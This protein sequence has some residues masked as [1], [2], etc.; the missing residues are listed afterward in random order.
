MIEVSK[1]ELNAAESLIL[2]VSLRRLIELL[3]KPK[4]ILS[5][6]IRYI[7]IVAGMAY[8]ISRPLC[9]EYTTDDRGTTAANICRE[10]FYVQF[11]NW[12]YFPLRR[13]AITDRRDGSYLWQQITRRHNS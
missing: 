5:I 7:R 10:T 8:Q 6:L 2:L 9:P 1:M 13:D 11:C 12:G 4:I 3:L